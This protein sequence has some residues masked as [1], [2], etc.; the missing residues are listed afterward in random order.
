MISWRV[1]RTAGNTQLC[2]K[3]HATFSD[4][5]Q[6]IEKMA[7]PTAQCLCHCTGFDL[8]QWEAFPLLPN[9]STPCSNIFFGSQ[10]KY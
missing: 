10:S 1:A 6:L 2:D 4:C 8:I 9:S 7:P 5:I 3:C